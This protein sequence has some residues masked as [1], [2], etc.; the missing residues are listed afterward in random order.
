M[1]S[2]G[3]HTVILEAHFPSCESLWLL[4]VIASQ[5]KASCRVA[6]VESEPAVGAAVGVA[7]LPICELTKRFAVLSAP[8]CW[9]GRPGDWAGDGWHVVRDEL[10]VVVVSADLVL[11]SNITA[12]PL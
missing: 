10:A 2:C 11:I 9:D 3:C 7:S 4:S 12:P 6:W 5:W 1:I 8:V